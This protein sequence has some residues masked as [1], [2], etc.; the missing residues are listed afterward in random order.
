[1]KVVGKCI[2]EKGFEV[3][4]PFVLPAGYSCNVHIT[5]NEGLLDVPTLLVDY[6][7]PTLNEWI[8][9]ERAHYQAAA[10]M[11]KSISEK[12]WV[13]LHNQ[14]YLISL[15]KEKK[16]DIICTWVLPDDRTDHD[17]ITFGLKILLDVITEKSGNKKY[18][19]GI[20]KSDSPAYI[21]NINHVFV[22]DRKAD[23]RKLIIQFWEV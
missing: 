17:N 14:K 4:F 23:H 18:G 21:G 6:E 1:M 3:P 16:H 15:N 7:L 10:N 13:F 9:V 19:L 22:T 8:N 20:L 11:K 12:L 2:N 5:K